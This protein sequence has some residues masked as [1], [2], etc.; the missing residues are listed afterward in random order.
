[1]SIWSN[2][3]DRSLEVIDKE[4][5][6]VKKPKKYKVIL[7]NDDYTTMEFV[8]FILKRV[9][10]KTEE[11]ANHIMWKIHKQ[12]TGVCGLYTFEIAES[13][14]YKVKTLARSEGHPLLCTLEE[15]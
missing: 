1:M 9:F 4:E 3:P 2:D 12:G 10:H 8:V 5:V 7:H 15:E 14:Q 13:K 11:E 6:K